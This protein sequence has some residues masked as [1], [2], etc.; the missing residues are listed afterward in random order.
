MTHGYKVCVAL[1][2]KQEHELSEHVFWLPQCG[3]Y[4]VSVNLPKLNISK[5]KQDKM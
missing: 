1:R 4:L 5:N 2:P 3:F